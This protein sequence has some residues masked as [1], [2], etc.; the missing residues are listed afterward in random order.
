MDDKYTQINDLI[1]QIA[2]GNPNITPE[3]IRRARAM[4]AG[5]TRSIEEIEAELLAYSKEI[6]QSKENTGDIEYS[7][8]E[9]QLTDQDT[10]PSI[11]NYTMDDGQE[12]FAE[13]NTDSKGNPTGIIHGM[14]H[15]IESTYKEEVE[16]EDSRTELDSMFENEE[17]HSLNE[18]V[19]QLQAPQFVKTPVKDN[20][21]G[22]NNN[23]GYSNVPSILI[24]TIILSIIAILISTTII[25]GN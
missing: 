19:T 4:Y 24:A 14:Y 18:T 3:Q 2:Q 17:T 21:S 1:T 23:G 6:E 12:A 11:I 16:L 10:I 13:I 25:I 22:S 5:D 20:E 9:E 15:N 8:T 7:I